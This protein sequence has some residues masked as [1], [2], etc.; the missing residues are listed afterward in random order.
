[1]PHDGGS[2]RRRSDGRPRMRR[3]RPTSEPS[4]A[5]SANAA[6]LHR[7][8]LG[9]RR[10][11]DQAIAADRDRQIVAAVLALGA[12]FGRH[13]PHGRVIEEQRLDDRLQ[14]VDEIVVPPHVRELVRENRFE[15]LRRQP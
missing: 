11:I 10:D 2:S 7:R 1:M 4:V 13:P 9:E 12:H 6:A 3:T 14:Q 8:Q 5:A 15:L